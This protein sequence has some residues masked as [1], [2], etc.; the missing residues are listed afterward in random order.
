MRGDGEAGYAIDPGWRVLF[1]DLG[2]DLDALSARAGLPADFLTHTEARL[3]MDEYFALWRA[4]EAEVDD[5]RLPLR[6]IEAYTVEAFHPAFFAALCSPS[7]DVA[8]ARLASYK[9]LIGPMALDVASRGELSLSLRWPDGAAPPPSLV[10]SEFVFLVH[11]AR[12]A[13]REPIRPSRVVLPE[14]AELTPELDLYFGAPIVRGAEQSLS[15]RAEDAHRPF[16]TANDSMWSVFEPAL[17]RRLSELDA[18]ASTHVRVRAA[19]LELLPS[20]QSSLEA[21][22]KKLALSTR[23]LQ[24]RLQADGVAYQAVLDRT[25]RDLALHYLRAT[26]LSTAEISFLLGFGEPRSFFRAF[27]A[28]MGETPQA[29]R[30]RSRAPIQAS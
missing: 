20:G 17:Q 10:T 15:F 4:L 25:R 30:Q 29:A 16:L 5:P 13:T 14:G 12:V 2:V 21:V 7:L 9:R 24:R 11:L 19:L 28:W 6:L 27:Q 18:E 8:A 23:T 3:A 22:A 1:R 26:D